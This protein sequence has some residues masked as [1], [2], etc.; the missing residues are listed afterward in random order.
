MS[1]TFYYAPMSTAEV[2]AAVLAELQWDPATRTLWSWGES[3]EGPER[4]GVEDEATAPVELASDLPTFAALP[5]VVPKEPAAGPPPEARPAAPPRRHVAAEA[6]RPDDLESRVRR[7]LEEAAPPGPTDA[8][9]AEAVCAL[10]WPNWPAYRGSLDLT[11][12]R[13]ALHGRRVD[14]RTLTRLGGSACTR[15]TPPAQASESPQRE[16]V[17]TDRSARPRRRRRREVDDRAATAAVLRR[18]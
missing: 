2:T 10:R 15:P 4:T 6:P 9:L 11:E 1:L 13:R 14:E 8:D 17:P 12:V 5:T 18:T 16:S 7:L 3:A